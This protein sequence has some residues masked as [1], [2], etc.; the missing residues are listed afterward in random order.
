MYIRSIPFGANKKMHEN[1][2]AHQPFHPVEGPLPFFSGQG[3]GVG[4]APSVARRA[5]SRGY[6]TVKLKGP[7]KQPFCT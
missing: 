7:G 1:I 5:T 6:L 2:Y 4:N 3:T